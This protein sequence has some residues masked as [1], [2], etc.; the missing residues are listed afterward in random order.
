MVSFLPNMKTLLVKQSDVFDLL[1]FILIFSK[2][3]FKSGNCCY[4][5]YYKKVVV[6]IK[7]AQN[8]YLNDVKHDENKYLNNPPISDNKISRKMIISIKFSKI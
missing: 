2:P 1:I 4:K 8:T 5:K 7:N 3:H 6:I